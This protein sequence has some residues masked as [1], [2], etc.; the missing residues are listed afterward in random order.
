MAASVVV[1]VVVLV[2]EEG[3]VYSFRLSATDHGNPTFLVSLCCFAVGNVV[4]L[5]TL[6]SCVFGNRSHAKRKR[7]AEH[8]VFRAGAKSI[9]VEPY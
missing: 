3:L 8:S 2:D 4:G 5:C 6:P 1:F 7:L 9:G